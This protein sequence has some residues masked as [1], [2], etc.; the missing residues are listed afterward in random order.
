MTRLE[1]EKQIIL[2]ILKKEFSKYKDS[3]SFSSLLA[4]DSIDSIKN[5]WDFGTKIVNKDIE[6]QLKKEGIDPL[7][8]DINI[9][10]W[11]VEYM[12]KP[13]KENWEEQ[14]KKKKYID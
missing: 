3:F 1:K 8:T 10:D 4:I 13:Y 12:S 6:K 11:C 7:N 9:D 2:K 14:A 5:V